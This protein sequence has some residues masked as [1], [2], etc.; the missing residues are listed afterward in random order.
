MAPPADAAEE[1]NLN[2]NSRK[3]AILFDKFDPDVEDFE[4]Y[5]DRLEQYLFVSGI[6]E[7][8]DR[9]A[10][11]ISVV[12]AKCYR[13]LKDLTAPTKPSEMKFEDICTRLSNYYNPK[14]TT[15]ATRYNFY[16]RNQKDN[17]SITDYV[18]NL[19]KLAQDCNF[20]TFRDTAI[21]DIFVCGLK[22][23]ATQRRLFAKEESEI[24]LEKV[25]KIALSMEMADRETE[26]LR[27]ERSSVKKVEHMNCYCCGGRNH[28]KKD[29]KYRSYTCE[30]CGQKGHL[31]RVCREG[32]S[33]K[34]KSNTKSKESSSKKKQRSKK[35]ASYKKKSKVYKCSD[36]ESS[37][38]ECTSNSESDD[39]NVHFINA[40]GSGHDKPIV[41]TVNV[42]QGISLDMEVDTGCGKSLISHQEFR[43][44]FGRQKIHKTSTKFKTLTGESLKVHGKVY[45]R[46]KG[47]DG[48][49]QKVPLYVIGEKGKFYPSL[50]GRDWLGQVKLDWQKIFGVKNVQ[51]NSDIPNSLEQEIANYEV[52]KEERGC[53]EKVK[54][55]LELAEGAEPKFYKP[56][57]VPFAIK[58]KVADELNKMV[59]D[60][61]LEKV[62]YSNWA[63]P[64]VPVRKPSGEVRVCGDYK[65]TINPVLKVKEH[66]LPTSEELLQ[67]LNGGEKFSKLDMSSAYQQVQLDENSREYLTINSHLGLFRYTRLAFGVSS[68]TAIFQELMEKILS[69]LEGVAVFVDDIIVTGKDDND[70]VKN[71][72]SVLQRLSDWGV[73]LKKSKCTF[74]KDNVEYLGFKI[75]KVGIHPTESKV[76]AI[77]DA[78]APTNKS[79]LHSLCGGISYYRKFIP[80]LATIMAP[81]NELKGHKK[82]VWDQKCEDAF[83]KVKERLIS[84]DVLV[85]YDPNKALILATDASP[86]G[87]SAIISHHDAETNSDRPIAFASR[88]LTQAERNYAQIERE[89]LAIIFGIQ[90]FHQY[91]YARKFTLYTDNKPL[92]LI[93]GPKKGIPVLAAQRLIR[94]A[95]MLG[96]Y[97][98]DIKYKSGQNNA[99]ADF[100]SRLPVNDT[101]QDIYDNDRDEFTAFWTTEGTETNISQIDNVPISNQRLKRATDNDPILSKVKNFVQHG[102]PVEDLGPEFTQFAKKRNELTVEEGCLL[103]GLRVV[104]P[105]KLQAAILSELHEQH[106]GIVRMKSL[107]R[108]H[109]YW[110]NIDADIEQ[111]VHDCKD[112]H[113]NSDP[114]KANSN[115]W[116]WP[117]K[118]GE[119]VHV[120][121]AGPFLDRMF[122]IIV[123]AHSK[124]ADVIPMKNT[125]TEATIRVLRTKFTEWGLP[126]VLVS[127]NGPQFISDEFKKFLKANCIEHIKSSVRHPSSNGEAERFVRTFKN[128][129]KA[130]KSR[131]GDIHQKLARF[132][133]SYRTT[134]H[135]TTKETPAK[136]FLGRELR[137]RLSALK[138]NLANSIQKKQ[139]KHVKDNRILEIG[140]PVLVRD[141][142]KDTEKWT[143][144]VIISKLGP[145]TYQ[146]EIE[147]E[148]VWKR[149]IDQ[150]KSI[151]TSKLAEFDDQPSQS[152]SYDYSR[153]DDLDQDNSSSVKQR[154]KQDEKSTKHAKDDHK[155]SEKS[156]KTSE[157]DTTRMTSKKS[158][159]SPKTC[160]QNQGN[161]PVNTN[162][163][164]LRRSKR[165]IKAPDRLTM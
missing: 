64:I 56:R 67:T 152:K 95:I 118:A 116:V 110:P 63:T 143:K 44:K 164:P 32:S 135:T 94:W 66:P 146:V 138:P 113:Q 18:S 137:T 62:D 130:T 65:I 84:S 120:D 100:L 8:E 42:D 6:K 23:K 125:T 129:M 132:L 46:V 109:V 131:K 21:R 127:D 153:F 103:W 39:E 140:D 160:K 2:S 98:Y 3:P 29:C 57:P 149:H 145:V 78:P 87:V 136:L 89:A 148:I 75:D 82:F 17:E 59:K 128:A 1:V 34:S 150:L 155:K 31:K 115:P 12:G 76:S 154:P 33:G 123:D 77:I 88:S 133:L 48:K 81:L 22:S 107:A 16:R 159:H 158:G 60:G 71:L 50:L 24:T 19:K 13:Q 102:W 25:E 73:R 72:K 112:C 105:K 147:D 43:E 74:M 117:N 10:T 27:E 124:W 68:A 79:E 15:L 51:S 37:D 161:Q 7:E 20:G 111:T 9:V 142:R 99:N 163:V 85:H 106:P 97:T 104:I 30:K 144:G 139:S 101:N 108:M 122:L 92:S 96:G 40:V 141:Y 157:K 70:H 165:T 126:Q 41:T 28:I 58:D 91:L 119:R 52:F 69:G 90:K 151:A 80:D 11:L 35:S 134:P 114:I 5:Q 121:F 156:I 49:S 93:L 38:D 36:S 4:C 47:V 14:K 54:V 55:K 61:V 45:V 26:E 86:Y 83:K 53:I 162:D